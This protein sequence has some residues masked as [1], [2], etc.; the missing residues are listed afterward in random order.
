[1]IP[2]TPPAVGTIWQH[3]LSRNRFIVTACMGG[4]VFYRMEKYTNVYHRDLLSFYTKF[5]QIE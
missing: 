5:S 4:L 2:A 3:D 1:M